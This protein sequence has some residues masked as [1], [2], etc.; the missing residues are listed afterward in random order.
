MASLEL[1]FLSPDKNNEGEARVILSIGDRIEIYTSENQHPET[2]PNM[3]VYGP[4]AKYAFWQTARQPIRMQKIARSYNN[5][6]YILLGEKT[7]GVVFEFQNTF[8]RCFPGRIC[9]YSIFIEHRIHKKI[10]YEW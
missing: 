3:R 2:G 6:G 8:L 1:Q 10:R 4:W 5:M 7:R 9:H